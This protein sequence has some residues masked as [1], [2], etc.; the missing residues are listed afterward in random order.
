MHWWHWSDPSFTLAFISAVGA[1]IVPVFLFYAARTGQRLAQ[2]AI[3]GQRRILAAQRRDQL[4]AALPEVS[5]KTTF[6]RLR[7]EVDQYRGEDR[8]LLL[9]ALRQ[10]PLEPLPWRIQNAEQVGDFVASLERRYR[11]PTHSMPFSHVREFLGGLPQ[12]LAEQCQDDLVGVLT[13]EAA[14]AQKPG[15]MFYRQL[16]S[17]G[18]WYL[19]A[20]LL[21]GCEKISPM[22]HGG[23]KLNILT[24]VLMA[25]DDLDQATA[26]GVQMPLHIVRPTDPDKFARDVQAAL[27]DLLHRGNLLFLNEWELV[28]Y[29]EPASAT[30]AWLILVVGRQS[31]VDDHIDMRCVQNL[32]KVVRQIPAEDADWGRD[33]RVVK[34]GLTLIRTKCPQLWVEYGREL[35]AATAVQV[36]TLDEKSS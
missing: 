3:E 20:P 31:G 10:N 17:Q 30:V 2:E 36:E 14:V 24:G 22:A 19:A 5:E 27:A 7:K 11:T 15:H 29:T 25:I 12:E 33:V 34:E 32:A 26:R 4:L 6:E 28:G 18:C 1:V 9:R 21:Y 35:V 23:L 16:V 8:R 13:G